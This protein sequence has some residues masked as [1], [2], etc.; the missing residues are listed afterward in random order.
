MEGA[1]LDNFQR[2]CDQLE[3]P[4]SATNLSGDGWSAPKDMARSMSYLTF[5]VMGDICFGSNLATLVSTKN[6]DLIGVISDGAQGLNTVGHLS[7]PNK[8]YVALI[9]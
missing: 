9:Q 1:V 7:Y 2:F 3:V 6:R 8:H 4:I 5:D